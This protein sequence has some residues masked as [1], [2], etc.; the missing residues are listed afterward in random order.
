MASVHY[1]TVADV[2]AKLHGIVD[3]VVVDRR[4][5]HNMADQLS[6][7][8][9]ANRALLVEGP[10]ESSVFYGIGDR[11]APGSLEAA[12]ISIVPVGSKTSI[13]L[14]HAIL[15]SISV[16]VYA[17]FDADGGFETRAKTTNKKQNDIDKERNNHA[18]ENHMLLQYFDLTEE[19][20]P[21]AVVTDKAAI[22]DDRIEAYLSKNW[23]EWLAACESVETEA[24]IS[25]TK[26]TLAYR[27]ATLKAKGA[28][29][30]M[31]SQIL[32]KVKG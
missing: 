3:A 26:N 22:F 16:P 4:L 14:A 9:F 20:F 1:A 12:G 23:K 30:E 24:G 21:D 15:T 13:P 29:P 32:A 18:A 17:L 7:A 25:L 11:S 2:K 27:T 8:L 6:I 28:V 5:D 31:L 10:T 19:D